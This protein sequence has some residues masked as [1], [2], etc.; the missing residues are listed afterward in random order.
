MLNFGMLNPAKL[1]LDRF[2]PLPEAECL[3][4]LLP[5]KAFPAD[6]GRG[7]TSW[8]KLASKEAGERRAFFSGDGLRRLE[9]CCFPS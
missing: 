9:T 4:R 2:L 6:F 1:N 5:P 7:H 8:E 3:C